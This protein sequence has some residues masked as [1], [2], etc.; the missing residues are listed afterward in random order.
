MSQTAAATPVGRVTKYR[1]VV[2]AILAVFYTMVYADR[3]NIGVALPLIQNEFK[4]TNFQA[5]SLASVFFIGYFVTQ[6]PAGFWYSKFGVRG[7]MSLSI[8]ATSAFTGLIGAAGSAGLI[9]LYRFGLGMAEGPCPV[10]V[11]TTINNWFPPKE[12]G[13]A[14][15]IYFAA[16]KFAP[17]IVPPV[18]VWIILHY[19]W[20]E[21]FYFFAAPGVITAAALYI[22][23][24]NRP[25]ESK[26]CSPAE[27][28]YIKDTT[29]ETRAAT[30]QGRQQSFGWLDTLIRVKHV[31]LLET[32]REVF[33]SW[34]IWANTIAYFMLINIIYGLLTWIPSYLVKE[35]H[36]SLTQMGF[37]AAMP[38]V[39]AVL[40]AVAG[41]RISDIYLGKRRKPLI[42]LS[43][44]ATIAM[45]LVLINVPGNQIIIALVL[46]VT[47]ILLNLGYPLFVVYPMGLTTSKTYPVANGLAGCTANL[48]GFFSPMIAGYLLDVFNYNAVFIFFGVCAAISLLVVLTMEEPI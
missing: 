44:I 12:K 16:A 40:G 33:L 22:F 13:L 14:N 37:V 35:K 30:V 9:K 19:G 27:L 39:G 5:G 24:R 11:S 23:V 46:L 31:R 45:M 48:G 42:L 26:F 36:L 34:N 17:V 1:W 28:A 29:I 25:E 15:G 20:R 43:T 8:V 4:L 18:S 3:A 32:N 6:L 10:G 47:G 21:V 7:L 2:M 41:G 38:W